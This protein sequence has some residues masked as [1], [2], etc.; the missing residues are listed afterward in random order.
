M[1]TDNTFITLRNEIARLEQE[2]KQL[3]S[4]NLFLDMISSDTF[5]IM[6][7]NMNKEIP[8]DDK[9]DIHIGDNVE[10]YYKG[11]LWIGVVNDRWISDVDKQNT[12]KQY[13]V[14]ARLY[15]SS[16]KIFVNWKCSVKNLKKTNKEI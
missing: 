5:D 16:E 7:E 6:I 13:E 11:D 10:F 15:K 8:K 12:P 9:D 1:N 3:R 4:S 14:R 2:N